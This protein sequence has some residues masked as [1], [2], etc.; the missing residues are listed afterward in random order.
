M[1]HRI[2]YRDIPWGVALGVLPGKIIGT[3]FIKPGITFRRDWKY[4]LTRAGRKLLILC[5]I[6]IVIG[7][8]AMAAENLS[9]GTFSGWLEH[10]WSAFNE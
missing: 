6:I 2:K 10:L 7:M 9:G 5:M 4:I 3:L 8:L 1:E